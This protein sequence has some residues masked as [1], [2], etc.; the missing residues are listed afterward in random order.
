[1]DFEKN[2]LT[3]FKNIDDLSQKEARKEAK[4]RVEERGGRATS[5]VSGETDYVVVGD[6]PGSKYENAKK[7][8]VRILDEQEFEKL[9]SGH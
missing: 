6:R 2:P 3:D 7:Q 9:L 8:N 5:T 4:V 1:M